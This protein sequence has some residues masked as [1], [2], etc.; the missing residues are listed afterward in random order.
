[1]KALTVQQPWASA[2]VAGDKRVE[3]RSWPTSFR[4]RIVIHAGGRV[5][6]A[7][8]AALA[9]AGVVVGEA[10]GGALIGSVEIVDCVRVAERS[11]FDAD[12]D[13]PLATGPWCWILR[14]PIRFDVPIACA[15]QLGLWAIPDDVAQRLE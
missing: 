10:P 6:P 13:D 14:N 5:D 12:V 8:A 7:G 3:N 9:A 4:G 15:G 11:L 2:I 1:M